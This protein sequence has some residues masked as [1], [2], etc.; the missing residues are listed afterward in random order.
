MGFALLFAG[1]GLQHAG[2]LPW[3]ADDE[4]ELRTLAAT[5][6]ADWRQ[7]LADPEACAR[8]AFAQPLLTSFALAAWRRLKDQLPAPQTIAGYSVGELA[9]FSV[10]GAFDAATA[11]S[12]AI[13]R[14]AFMDDCARQAAPTGLIGVTG[15][16]AEALATLRQRHGLELA[17]DSGSTV[18]L[19][20]PRPALQAFCADAEA[21]DVRCTTLRVELASHTRWMAGASLAL[22][23]RLAGIEVRR[24][25]WV[26]YANATGRR[27]LTA[28]DARRDLA[29]QVAQCVRWTDCLQGIAE[30]RIGCV[31]EIGAGAA[32]SRQWN[33][34]YPG[35][36]ARSADEFRS[37]DAIVSWVEKHAA[38]R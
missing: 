12:L 24:P 19:G 29:A 33:E 13:E 7:R 34:R 26:L 32:L 3:L 10:A 8:N 36:P 6:G 38:S 5:L 17:I 30:R 21:L 35:I 22:A 15:L 11:Q 18:I 23:R 1:Q 16:P 9:A 25:A 28:D 20:G 27:V 31:L 4:P 14:A 2:M 37:A